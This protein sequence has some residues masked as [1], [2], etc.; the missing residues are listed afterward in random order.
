MKDNYLTVTALTRYVKRKID[1]DPHLRQVWLRGEISNFK[2]HSR[3]H[4]YM[5]IKDDNARIQAVM[6]SSNNSRLVFRPENG[7]S[8]LI[9]GEVSV[10]EASGQYQL[11]IRDMEPD[12]IGALYQAFEQLK[13]KLQTEG[14]FLDDQKKK[15]P[16]YPNHVGVI[17]SPTG[18]AVRDIVTTIERRAPSVKITVLP[19]SV[20]GP[21]ATSSIVKKIQYANAFPEEYDVL[22][23][24][25][26][27][28]SIEE[29]WSFNE[30][31]VARAIYASEIPVISAVGHETDTTI[32]DFVSDLRAPT[33]TG[34]AELAVPSQKEQLDKVSYLA[35]RLSQVMR[36]DIQMHR[37]RLESLSQTYA[38]K[39][40][41]QLIAQKEQELDS[42]LDSLNKSLKARME[43][44][45]LRYTHLKQRLDTQ[46]PEQE[47][48]TAADKNSKLLAELNRSMKQLF[49]KTESDLQTSINKLTLVNPLAVMARG[50]GISY[51]QDGDVI[52]SI[53]DVN[54]G[55]PIDVRLQDGYLHANVQ[56]IKEVDQSGGRKEI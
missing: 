20:Q 55:D 43:Q 7:M 24:G 19:V 42:M 32:A 47:I 9:R 5:T 31:A 8:V 34:A 15:I 1:T 13:E 35:Q 37:K 26:G 10:Y 50:Y 22:I 17:T 40:P 48:K 51:S 33:P 53:K 46:H 36:T 2:H 27:G 52:K 49:A 23:V 30:E 44:K 56:K 39:Y 14:L 16:A 21:Q 4:M 38:F 54:E 18:A 41:K 29:L 3:G 28:G 25:R 12:G 6:F 45:Q 11:Y